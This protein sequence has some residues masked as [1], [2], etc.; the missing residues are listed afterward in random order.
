MAESGLN[1]EEIRQQSRHK[2]YETLQ[3][4]IQMS[5]Q[6]VKEA[7]MKGMSLDIKP[8]KIKTQPEPVPEIKNQQNPP[9]LHLQLA[10]RLASGEISEQVYLQAIRSL[11]TPVQTGEAFSYQ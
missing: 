10:Q 8:E 11:K 1:L 6:H 7:Y 4:Y 5:D 3:G 2:R 9:N